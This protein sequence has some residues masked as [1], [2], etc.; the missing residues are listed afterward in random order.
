MFQQFKQKQI[1]VIFVKGAGDGS[2]ENGLQKTTW[3]EFVGQMS[4]FTPSASKDVG[5]FLPVM[6]KPPQEWVR[7]ESNLLD[8]KEKTFRNK[9]NL[10]HVT[11]AVIDLDEKGALEQAQ[12]KFQGI[13]HIIHSTF[14]YSPETP[15]K[16]RMVMPL[17]NP[18]PVDQWERT[19]VHLMAGIDGDYA[20]KNVSRG[21][22][23]PSINT[24][25]NME[26]VFIHSEGK[27]LTQ[28]KIM[29]LAENNMD[30]KAVKALEKL[31]TKGGNVSK[32]DKIHPSGMLIESKYTGS[33]LS[34]EGFMKRHKKKVDFHFDGGKGNRH[35]YAIDVINSE[36][37]IFSDNTRFD[38][39]IEFIY[40]STLENSTS[41]LSSGN[42]G[43]EIPEIIQSGMSIMMPTEKLKDKQFLSSVTDGINKG[44]QA[45]VQ[46]E[47]SGKWS[48]EPTVFEPKRLGNS[49]KSFKARYFR[50]L[51]AFEVKCQEIVDSGNQSPKIAFM[52]AFNEKIVVPVLSR[53]LSGNTAFDVQSMGRFFLDLMKE[54]NIGSNPVNEYLNLSKKLSSY[55]SGL[56]FPV[57]KEQNL[58]PEKVFDRLSEVAALS[59]LMEMVEKE[60]KNKFK[61]RLNAQANNQEPQI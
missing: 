42:T 29:D 41:P 15:Y 16:Y 39:M 48:F 17:E 22:Y 27:M 47:K 36:M 6:A 51:G 60:N 4:Q 25:N 37:G 20:C 45:S 53:E 38:L 12:R 32:A 49:L 21:Y 59:P 61:K 5:M 8:G 43:D 1:P 24:A 31:E 57:I 44:L 26:P 54:N 7:G 28:E 35:D 52:K 30:A 33:D 3:Q 58:T 14:S 2:I 19:F 18:I 23:V 50:E 40:R 11:M 34:Y 10:T 56:N 13:E 55:I 9:N 46:A